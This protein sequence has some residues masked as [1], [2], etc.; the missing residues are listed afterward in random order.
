MSQRAKN[1]LVPVVP[2]DSEEL[3]R[4]ALEGTDEWGGT[5]LYLI[6]PMQTQ[7]RKVAQAMN[8]LAQMP[9]ETD[10]LVYEEAVMTAM[11]GDEAKAKEM[12][13]GMKK[14]LQDQVTR[15][16]PHMAIGPVMTKQNEKTLL[17]RLLTTNGGNPGDDWPTV[18]A[19]LNF[20][21]LV[22]KAV[23]RGSDK[24]MT[25]AEGLVW[26]QRFQAAQQGWAVAGYTVET[27][28]LVQ[29][30][31]KEHWALVTPTPRRAAA[32]QSEQKRK[33][34]QVDAGAGEEDQ[35]PTAM[36]KLKNLFWS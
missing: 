10:Q 33:K 5:L 27:P 26:V 30:R 12:T 16:K 8:R 19:L 28:E 13:R 32:V 22:M 24:P 14:A 4:G 31:W 23:T 15:C 21:G 11:A 3:M 17:V 35:K 6:G 7:S 20:A 25:E 34:D 2:P 1:Q 18:V 29:S 9:G 36:K